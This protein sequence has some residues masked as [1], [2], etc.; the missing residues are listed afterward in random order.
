M[1]HRIRRSS[2]L[3]FLS[4]SRSVTDVPKRPWEA[5]YDIIPFDWQAVETESSRELDPFASS[6]DG[7]DND[8]NA[9]INNTN[10]GGNNGRLDNS[11]NMPPQSRSQSLLRLDE[12]PGYGI[13]RISGWSDG[14]ESTPRIRGPQLAH[15][16]SVDLDLRMTDYTAQYQPSDE[17]CKLTSFLPCIG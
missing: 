6:S 11:N 2:S 13:V 3:L 16:S 9:I 5:H 17:E 4:S 7:E 8:N 12:F 10:A 15:M 1:V 14:P